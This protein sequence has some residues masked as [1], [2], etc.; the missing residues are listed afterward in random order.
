MRQQGEMKVPETQVVTEVF[1]L[2]VR[3]SESRSEAEGLLS[4]L[5]AEGLPS[6]SLQVQSLSKLWHM[7]CR[8]QQN[9]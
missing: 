2:L 4:M 5:D 9:E 3:G 1:L 6:L 8:Q 7:L